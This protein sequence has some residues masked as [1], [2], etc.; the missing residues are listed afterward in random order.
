MVV[1]LHLWL[2]VLVSYNDVRY[3]QPNN[4]LLDESIQLFVNI[5][6]QSLYILRSN[7]NVAM[8]DLLTIGTSHLIVPLHVRQHQLYS[9]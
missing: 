2:L 1:F 5:H 9:F 3:M 7:V 4:M 8:K 6:A